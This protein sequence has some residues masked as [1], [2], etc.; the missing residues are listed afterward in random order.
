MKL[1]AIN[2]SIGDKV[3]VFLNMA[4][5]VSSAITPLS[6]PATIIGVY[7]SPTNAPALYLIGWKVGYPKPKDQR[8][9]K[10][11]TF[12]SSP[13]STAFK[14]APDKHLYDEAMW[15][16]AQYEATGLT[17][18]KGMGGTNMNTAVKASGIPGITAG[19]KTVYENGKLSAG[20][21]LDEMKRLAS[22]RPETKCKNKT[23]RSTVFV[24][25]AK[26]WNCQTL[27]PGKP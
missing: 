18:P 10:A 6:I 21:T 8:L 13:Y 2:P 11:S 24:D 25:D 3:A 16:P 12:I 19:M 9:A 1:S 14:F 4:H 27:N 17:I 20:Q 22:S 23:C 5:E 26:C 7:Y 15:C